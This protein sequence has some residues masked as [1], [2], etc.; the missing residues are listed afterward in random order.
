[1]KKV[2]VLVS[3]LLTLLLTVLPVHSDHEDA[4]Q[5][6]VADSL[7]NMEY[8][9]ISAEFTDF[10]KLGVLLFGTNQN[11]EAGIFALGPLNAVDVQ[12]VSTSILTILAVLAPVT[13]PL[14]R[15]RGCDVMRCQTRSLNSDT[16]RQNGQTVQI[17]GSASLPNRI[18]RPAT[19]YAQ[20]ML[21]ALEQNGLLGGRSPDL[22]AVIT[23][24]APSSVTGEGVPGGQS[25]GDNGNTAQ[26]GLDNSA[27]SD[28]QSEAPAAMVGRE[29]YRSANNT[30]A[31]V[32]VVVPGW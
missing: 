24:L 23:N 7:G 31:V 17:A 5:K 9:Y 1:M 10:N 8:D 2:L 11:G 21:D 22:E 28:Y 14:K 27:G 15:G 3:L 4:V 18:S 26:N 32:G 30:E 12:A 6:Q 16:Q 25:A 19:E 20:L 13:T 29:Y